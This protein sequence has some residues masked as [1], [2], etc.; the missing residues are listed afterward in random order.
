M[1]TTQKGGDRVIATFRWAGRKN[2]LAGNLG[3][4]ETEKKSIAW[5]G[6]CEGARDLC[7]WHRGSGGQRLFL[8]KALFFGY[9]FLRCIELAEMSQQKKVT[10]PEASNSMMIS[11]LVK[12]PLNSS[13]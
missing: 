6:K 8:R 2:R 13:I 9:F 1:F 10:P 12:K 5:A 3:C 11:F 7:G 4:G